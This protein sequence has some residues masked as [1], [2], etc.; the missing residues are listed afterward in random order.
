MRRTHGELESA[1]ITAARDMPKR[2]GEETGLTTKRARLAMEHLGLVQLAPK[3][4]KFT[5]KLVRKSC[6]QWN[7]GNDAGA[8]RRGPSRQAEVGRGTRGGDRRADWPGR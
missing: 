7:R 1:G 6:A 3:A 4:R 8:A 2:V 5:P